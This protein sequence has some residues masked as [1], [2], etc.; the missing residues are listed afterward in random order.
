MKKTMAMI[1]AAILLVLPVA[2]AQQTPAND[3]EAEKEA[4]KMIG[5][6]QK[7]LSKAT[8]DDDRVTAIHVLGGTRHPKILDI[9]KKLLV[10]YS[11][12]INTAAAEEVGQYSKSQDAAEALTQAI[13]SSNKNKDMIK[14]YFKALGQVRFYGS[15]KFIQGYFQFPDEEVSRAAIE[16][17]AAIRSRESIEP[18][19]MFLLELEQKDLM[20]KQKPTPPPDPNKK[21]T[22]EEQAAQAAADM[23]KRRV[24]ALLPAVNSALGAITKQNHPNARDWVDWWKKN[25][26]TFKVED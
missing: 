14:T 13:K 7:T 2:S 26:A 18:L 3:K 8:T 21:P 10:G 11:P 22:P 6:F 5:E 16:T 19:I 4:K 15:A 1:V 20:F 12:A 25:K 24:A 23:E 9:L 17:A